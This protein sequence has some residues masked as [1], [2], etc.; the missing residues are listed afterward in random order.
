MI[1]VNVDSME[2]I[3]ENSYKNFHAKGLDY[4][5]IRRTPE[6]T[7]KYY[8]FEGDFTKLPEVVNPH[9]HRYAFMTT[10]VAGQVENICYL[11]SDDG[12]HV[13]E[14]PKTYQKFEWMTPL[15]GGSGFTWAGEQELFE[16]DRTVYPVG[17]SYYMR[18]PEIHT[19]KF[20]QHN[21]IIALSQYR[22]TV[23][24]DQPTITYA[25]SEPSLTGLYEKFTP[26]E[27]TKKVRVLESLLGV[28]IVKYIK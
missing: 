12:Y 3:V 7:L 24:L 19:I 9:D 21:S 27:I 5:C 25:E 16:C 11:P 8:F 10:T 18:A 6:Q 23:P 1:G 22:D 13:C 26:D 14:R 2:D 15:N 17:R 28:D 4:V 20:R